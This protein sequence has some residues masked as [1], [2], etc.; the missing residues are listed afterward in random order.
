MSTHKFGVAL[1]AIALVLGLAVAIRL[2]DPGT[3]PESRVVGADVKVPPDAVLARVVSHVDGDTLRLVG[4]SGS[5]AL[6][7][8][9]HTTVRLLEIDTPEHGR[10][11][12][13]AE[14]YAE[15]ASKVL[16]DMLPAGAEVWVRR[17]EQLRDSYGR[18][19]LYLWTADGEF[20]NLELVR[21]GFATAVLFE[22][23]DRYIDLMRRAESQARSEGRG[24]WGACGQGR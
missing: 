10:D 12:A 16:R 15:Q 20:V 14:C 7:A 18:T 2:A 8:E 9:E 24:L 17:D 3:N 11:G 19:L 6:S 13:P 21:Q 22:P 4:E 1:L 5:A 23:N